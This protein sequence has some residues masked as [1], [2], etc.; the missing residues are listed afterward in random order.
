MHHLD[1]WYII[2]QCSSSRC[3]HNFFKI[4][5]SVVGHILKTTVLLIKSNR[6]PKIGEDH[7]RRIED[8]QNKVLI[9]TPKGKWMT[10]RSWVILVHILLIS[11]LMRPWITIRWM[12]R[13]IIRSQIVRTCPGWT[14]GK[15]KTGWCSIRTTWCRRERCLRSIAILGNFRIIRGRNQISREV[16]AVVR[17][18]SNVGNILNSVNIS[19]VSRCHN[20]V[21][22]HLHSCIN[23]THWWNIMRVQKVNQ[24]I[25]RMLVIVDWDIHN[26]PIFNN[27]IQ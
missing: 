23:S 5:K 25:Y 12:K 3:H 13:I 18:Y 11:S 4:V 27:S 8:H 20:Q 24:V 1:P 22:L 15:V 7:S 10:V 9:L 21:V 19:R 26:H 2:N 16:L 6:I 14:Y 17:K